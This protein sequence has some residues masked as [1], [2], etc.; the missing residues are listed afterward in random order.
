MQ[1]VKIILWNEHKFKSFYL[2]ELKIHSNATISSLKSWRKVNQ[3]LLEHIFTQNLGFI[4]VK[5][6]PLLLRFFKDVFFQ[7]LKDNEISQQ[8]F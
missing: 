2:K 6:L 1:T 4:S 3:R 8:I 5:Q 7:W